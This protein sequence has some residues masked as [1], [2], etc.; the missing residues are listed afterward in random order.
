MR[1][2]GGKVASKGT[3]AC[4]IVPRW[5]VLNMFS[6][7]SLCPCGVRNQLPNDQV[8]K[9]SLLRFPNREN[10]DNNSFFTKLFQEEKET[11]NTIC[12]VYHLALYSVLKEEN[13]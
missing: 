8:L 13:H 9:L 1:V 3:G 6:S 4:K 12:P 10:G 5:A 2:G 7:M 11:V